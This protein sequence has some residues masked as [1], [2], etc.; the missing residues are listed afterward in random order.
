MDSVLIAP[1]LTLTEALYETAA[2]GIAYYAQDLLL[3]WQEFTAPASWWLIPD[4]TGRLSR[5]EVTL[6]ETRTRTVKVNIWFAPDLRGPDGT[7]CPHSHPWPFESHILHGGYT[8]DRYVLDHGQV[9]T[10]A[11]R[12]HTR[13]TTNTVDR[14]LYH[15]VTGLH[16]APGETVSLMLCGRGERGTWGHLDPANGVVTPP[17]RDPHFPENLRALN[18]HR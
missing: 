17:Q 4:G 13:G 1:G 6:T 14:T 2:A 9:R 7:P 18:P 5:A 11:G 16:T 8:E 10:E 12:Q 15:E 3:S